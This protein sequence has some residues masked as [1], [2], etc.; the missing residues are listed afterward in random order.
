MWSF[1]FLFS[2]LISCVL[3]IDTFEDA[4]NE[5]FQLK[6]PNVCVDQREER[7]AINIT[8]LQSQDVKEYTWCLKVPPRSVN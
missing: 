4:T 6:G 5:E 3:G 2:V 1:L 7:K 8:Y